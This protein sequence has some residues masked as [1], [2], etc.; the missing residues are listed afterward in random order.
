MYGMVRIE[1]RC[2]ALL[3]TTRNL[4]SASATPVMV[5]MI[6]ETHQQACLTATWRGRVWIIMAMRMVEESKPLTYSRNSQYPEDD[7]VRLCSKR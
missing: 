1:E 2:S 7:T 3:T 4:V 5:R 6:K